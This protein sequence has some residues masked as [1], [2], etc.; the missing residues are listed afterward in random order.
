MNERVTRLLPRLIRSLETLESDAEIAN[1]VRVI[2]AQAGKGFFETIAGDGEPDVADQVSMAHPEQRYAARLRSMGAMLRLIEPRLLDRC[3]PELDQAVQRT[4]EALMNAG[5][6]D[7]LD[8]LLTML[9]MREIITKAGE[10]IALYSER[11]RANS[12]VTSEL[13]AAMKTLAEQMQ[14]T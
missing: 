11:D 10:R 2:R 13:H 8:L 7:R 12:K 4:R 14:R 1:T 6:V 5:M 3:D 9:C